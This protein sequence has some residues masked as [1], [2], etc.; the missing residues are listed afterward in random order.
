MITALYFYFC[1]PYN[2]LTTKNLVSISQQTV[3]PLCP[4]HSPLPPSTPVTTTG[5]CI[6]VCLL[7]DLAC[8]FYFH[9]LVFF[10][11]HI[12]VKSYIFV[13]LHLAYFT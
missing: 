12:L 6:Y 7:F 1:I 13:F 10:I 5:L 9:L 3:H 11:F 8:L 2:V 4:F